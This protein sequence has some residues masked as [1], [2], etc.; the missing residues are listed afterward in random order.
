[1]RTRC[2]GITLVLALLGTQVAAAQVKALKKALKRTSTEEREERARVKIEALADELYVTDEVFRDLVDRH[3]QTILRGHSELA[4][5]INTSKPSEVVVIRED[6]FRR[7]TGEND[8]YDNLMVQSYVNR[9]GQ[10]LVPEHST[11]LCT[12]R[13][14]VHPV[15][16]A[17]ALSPGTIYLSTG[18]ISLLENEAQL[19]YVLAHEMA[20]VHLEH[21]KQKSLIV[22]GTAE[23][24]ERRE[25]KL[26]WKMLGAITAG[27]VVGAQVRRLERLAPRARQPGGEVRA[28]PRFRS[29]G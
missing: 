12:F 21:W 22:Y 8:L 9:L 2:L 11:A 3:Y 17:E 25:K 13:L 29:P 27:A 18:L 19:A 24:L 14:V 20:H 26:A 7:H 15:P 10:R 16:H 4:Y 5:K 6:R 28:G 23:Y 1:M